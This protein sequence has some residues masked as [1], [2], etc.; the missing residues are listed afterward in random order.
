[1][2]VICRNCGGSHPVWDCTKPSKEP[3]TLPVGEKQ[4]RTCEPE[5]TRNQGMPTKSTA[6][7]KDVIICPGNMTDSKASHRQA[8]SV[9]GTQALPVDYSIR[10]KAMDRLVADSADEL[11]PQKPKGGRPPTG[12]DKREY[13]RKFMADKRAATKLGI[14]VKEFRSGKGKE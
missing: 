13:Q 9:A 14:S 2:A 4:Q 8:M 3:L 1:M 6:S 11:F 5:R 12:F 7:R 10:S